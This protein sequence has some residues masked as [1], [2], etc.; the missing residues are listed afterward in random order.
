[1]TSNAANRPSHLGG[2]IDADAALKAARF[3]ELCD[4][5]ELPVVFVVD[6]PGF[7]V[8]LDSER[9]AAVRKMTKMFVVGANI[10]VCSTCDRSDCGRC[11]SSL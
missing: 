7:M 9:E 4:A 6:C 5:F 10:T 11:Q 3:M 1:M 8:G 2:A